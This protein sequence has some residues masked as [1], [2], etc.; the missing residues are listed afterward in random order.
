MKQ[1]AYPLPILVVLGL[2]GIPDGDMEQLKAWCGN[3]LL[4]VL[5]RPSAEQQISI[6]QNIV[7]FWNYTKAFCEQR[8]REPQDDLTSDLAAIATV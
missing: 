1:F 4:F 5:G 3:R 8:R 7:A 2:C 6:A